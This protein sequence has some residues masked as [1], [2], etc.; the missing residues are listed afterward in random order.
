MSVDEPTHDDTTRSKG[1]STRFFHDQEQK[2]NIFEPRNNVPTGILH[3][4][5][6]NRDHE[7]TKSN[8]CNFTSIWFYFLLNTTFS[9]FNQS[10]KISITHVSRW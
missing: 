8:K 10:T 4:T 2:A 9:S 1:D 6:E 7:K 3:K 5:A